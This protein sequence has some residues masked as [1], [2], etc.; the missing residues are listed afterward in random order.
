MIV[1]EYG[2]GSD[3]RIHTLR[4]RPFDFSSEYQQTYLEHYLPVLEETPYVCGGSHWNFVD[5]GSAVRDE[6]MPRINNNFISHTKLPVL[7]FLS[8][9]APA[10]ETDTGAVSPA[11]VLCPLFRFTEFLVLFHC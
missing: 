3:K 1:S 7:P 10:S 4:P 8:I 11:S 5:F 6:S 2:A 9:Y